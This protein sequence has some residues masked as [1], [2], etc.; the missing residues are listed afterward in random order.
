[1][2]QVY[3]RL[4]DDGEETFLGASGRKKFT[5]ATV[6]AGV[7][8]LCYRIIAFRSTAR[9]DTAEFPVNLGISGRMSAS[10]FVPRSEQRAA[11]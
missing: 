11:A 2:Y 10:P 7:R 4:G 9:G 8:T 1:M 6:P 3:R 5:G